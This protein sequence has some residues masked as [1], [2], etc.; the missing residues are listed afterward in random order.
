MPW[1]PD[2]LDPSAPA[3]LPASAATSGERSLAPRGALS[4]G[5]RTG[6]ADAGPRDGQ[7]GEASPEPVIHVT[8]GR[9]EVRAARQAKPKPRPARAAAA[10]RLSLDDYQRRRREGGA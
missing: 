10:P 2:L 9:I 6:N 3:R 7:R 1:V 8:I 5:M 4:E